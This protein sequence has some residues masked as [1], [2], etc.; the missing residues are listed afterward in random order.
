M[1][2]GAVDSVLELYYFVL[3]WQDFR[4]LNPGWGN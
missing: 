3:D 1:K 2:E 4:I